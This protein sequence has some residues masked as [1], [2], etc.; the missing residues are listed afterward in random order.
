[1]SLWKA[2]YHFVWGTKNREHLLHGPRPA[3]VR[4]TIIAISRE[5]ESLVHA[6]GFMPEHV[7]LLISIPPKFAPASFIQRAKGVATRNVNI[8]TEHSLGHFSWQGEYGVVTI[9][10]RSLVDVKRYVENQPERHLRN[11]LWPDFE[12]TVDPRFN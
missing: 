8:E 6:I 1:M 5:Y 10:E 4:E 9:A 7:H 12:R 11:Q 2:Y 3:I